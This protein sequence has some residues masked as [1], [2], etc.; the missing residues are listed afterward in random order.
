M[1][2]TIYPHKNH[3]L[4]WGAWQ[5][6]QFVVE[7]EALSSDPQYPCR[8]ERIAHTSASSSSTWNGR[9][10][11]D[12]PWKLTSQGSQGYTAE[13]SM[14]PCIQPDTRQ[15]LISEDILRPP[16]AHCGTWMPPFPVTIFL[17]YFLSWA[18]ILALRRHPD[19][20][21]SRSECNNYVPGS[22]GDTVRPHT[23]TKESKR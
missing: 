13:N 14:R 7:S 4:G 23:H 22:L 18:V 5:V 17:K 15:R 1:H 8:C 11:Q 20:W 9:Q 3:S 12:N 2:P 6:T 21:N 19:C 16:Y 10:R